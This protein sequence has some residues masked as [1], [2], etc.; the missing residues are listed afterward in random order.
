MI[1][2]GPVGL[3]SLPAA[4]ALPVVYATELE[5]LDSGN[6]YWDGSMIWP[7]VLLCRTEEDAETLTAELNSLSLDDFRAG[8]GTEELLAE[9]DLIRAWQH[10]DVVRYRPARID[11]PRTYRYLAKVPASLA[12]LANLPEF[13]QQ[14]RLA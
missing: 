12:A 8:L 1:Q 9:D 3:L 4:L 11:N 10:F 5:R 6:I 7:E 13:M 2:Y 14:R